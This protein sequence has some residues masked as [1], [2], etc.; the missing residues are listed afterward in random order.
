MRATLTLAVLGIATLGLNGCALSDPKEDPVQIRLNDLDTRLSNVQ[1]V[2]DNQSLVQLSQRI[3]ALEA[4]LRQLR[5]S[6]EEQQNA[7]E[8]QRKQQRDLYADLNQRLAALEQQVKGGAPAAGGGEG[9]GPVAAATGA[10]A[11]GT[12]AGGGA[13]AGATTEDQLAYQH[14]FDTLKAGDYV[15]AAT[16][17]SA[18]MQRYPMSSLIDNAQYWQGEAYYVNRDYEHAAGAF[19]AVGQKWPN[20]RKAPDALLKLGYT[21]VEQKR[22]AEA[23][24]TLA[25]V[26]QRFPGSDAAKLAADKLQKMPA[27]QR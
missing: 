15:G 10:V 2:I 5:G 22:Y 11:G 6:S 26:S 20:S 8:L 25:A 27:D 17:F 19:R 7:T 13:N 3:D 18:F 1:R 12:G 4:Q 21:L 14:A 16:E 9:A 24:Q 23:R